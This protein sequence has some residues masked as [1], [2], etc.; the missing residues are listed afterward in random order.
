MKKFWI[1][2]EDIIIAQGSTGS[3][4]CAKRRTS[5]HFTERKQIDI[6][7]NFA[8]ELIKTGEIKLGKLVAAEIIADYLTNLLTPKEIIS[9][10]DSKDILR[11]RVYAHIIECKKQF[12][13]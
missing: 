5:K 2:Q 8:M 1:K 3:I 7:L 9:E 6:R 4:E 12:W 13:C 10:I 11:A